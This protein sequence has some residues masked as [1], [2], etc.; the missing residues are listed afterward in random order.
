MEEFI[1]ENTSHPE[2]L[3][4]FNAAMQASLGCDTANISALFFLA[5]ANA[6]GGVMNLFL[7]E[8][9]SAQEFRTAGGTQQFCVKLIERVGKE[10]L[11]LGHSVKKITQ[12]TN[13]ARVEVAN[14]TTFVANKVTN[15]SVKSGQCLAVGH[16]ATDGL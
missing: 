13:E 16:T 7:V 2:V 15:A 14:G 9:Q 5:Y 1:R 8:N 12:K 11:Y 10:N 6:A 4:I 3:D